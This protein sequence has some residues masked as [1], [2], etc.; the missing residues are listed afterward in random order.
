VNLKIAGKKLVKQ[1]YITQTHSFFEKYGTKAII[2][3]RFVPI[4][5]TFTPFVAGVGK[6]SYRN[7]FLP[8]DIVG[9]FLWI[10]SMS[11]S[12]YFLGNLP[13]FQEHFEAVVLGIILLSVSPMVIAFLKAKLSSKK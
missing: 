8:Y 11:L 13:F 3:A 2:M 9:G 10:S 1:E 4:V 5:R 6:M 12:G 7:K